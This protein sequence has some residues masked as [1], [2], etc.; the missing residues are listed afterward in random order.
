VDNNEVIRY[1]DM[2]PAEMQGS[3]G[4]GIDMNEDHK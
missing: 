3:F 2:T 4:F 1:E